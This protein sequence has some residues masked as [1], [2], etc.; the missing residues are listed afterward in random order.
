MKR[1]ECR[2]LRIALL[3]IVRSTSLYSIYLFRVDVLVFKGV[4]LVALALMC[5]IYF[6][7]LTLDCTIQL[8]IEFID[9]LHLLFGLAAEMAILLITRVTFLAIVAFLQFLFW[10]SVLALTVPIAAAVAA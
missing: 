2:S 8:L 4:L 1:T 7:V 10:P 6:V 5:P 3:V 9:I